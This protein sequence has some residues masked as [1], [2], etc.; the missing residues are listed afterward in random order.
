MGSVTT[1]WGAP[2]GQAKRTSPEI[3]VVTMT[4]A[5]FTLSSTSVATGI[6]PA[7]AAPAAASHVATRPRPRQA[8]PDNHPA[9][10]RRLVVARL[11]SARVT[12]RLQQPAK[13]LR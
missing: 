3:L 12:G 9:S 2:L 6:S 5:G 7:R 4:T 11:P 8:L 13:R 1:R 10:G